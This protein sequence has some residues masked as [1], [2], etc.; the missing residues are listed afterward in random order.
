MDQDSYNSPTEYRRQSAI[1]G[2]DHENKLYGNTLDTSSQD[3]VLPQTALYNMTGI[4]PCA[5]SISPQPAS[6]AHSPFGSFQRSWQSKLDYSTAL[7][8]SRPS[9]CGK[10]KRTEAE[11]VNTAINHQGQS[12]GQI[13][14][15]ISKSARIGNQ[16]IMQVSP[17]YLCISSSADEQWRDWFRC[18]FETVQQSA[19]RHIAK[20]WIKMIHPRK[21]SSHPYNGRVV[22]QKKALTLTSSRPPYWPDHIQYRE[23]DHIKKGG[24]I[25]NTSSFFPTPC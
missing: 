22:Q 4:N 21:Q 19:C 20:E 8:S 6:G 13:T 11:V 16:P 2:C 25:A 5:Y 23:P 15:P 17:R 14:E 10:R 18:A 9:H 12:P 1:I 7:P 3:A 24:M